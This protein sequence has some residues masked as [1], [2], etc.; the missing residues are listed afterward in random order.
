MNSPHLIKIEHDLRVLSLE[1]LEWLLERI[2]KR[3]QE[4]KQ[5]LNKFNDVK[6]MNEQLVA[7]ASDLDIQ[8]EITTI[9]NEFSITEMDGLEKL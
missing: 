4:K 5:I 2:E 3:V 1:E 9:N 8:T 6:Y 7:M